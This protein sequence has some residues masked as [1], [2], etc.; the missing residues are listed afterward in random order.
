MSI[1]IGKIIRAEMKEQG[2]SSAQ[3][4]EEIQV[5]N[6]QNID[7]DLKLE[8]LPI[9]KVALYSSALNRNFLKCYNEI[10]PFKSFYE[11]DIKEIEK[12]LKDEIEKLKNKLAESQLT[13]SIQQETILTQKQLINT[14]AMLI[15]KEN[16]TIGGMED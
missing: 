9:D 13:I 1:N 2:L 16:P 5:K 14:Q 15:E 10:E 3:L 7:Y 12:P 4:I 11:A 8:A 6:A